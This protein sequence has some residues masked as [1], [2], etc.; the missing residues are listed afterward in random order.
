MLYSELFFTSLRTVNIIILL[1]V[2]YIY[3]LCIQYMNYCTLP[4]CW[5]FVKSLF[6]HGTFINHKINKF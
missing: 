2:L 3:H 4:A 1:Y 5:I 6:L